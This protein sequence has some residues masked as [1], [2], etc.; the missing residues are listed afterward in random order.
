MDS[1][2]KRIYIPMSETAFYILF[3]LQG[4][5]HGYGIGQEVKQITNNEVTISPGTM[6]GTLSKMEKDGL[7]QFVRVEEKRKLYQITDL[8]KDILEIE[9]KRIKRLYNNSLGEVYNG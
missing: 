5:N 6:Y 4:P 8:G 9:L 1:K 2:L 3:Y 7:I